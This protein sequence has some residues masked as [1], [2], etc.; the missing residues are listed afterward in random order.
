L[1]RRHINNVGARR[2]AAARSHS[3]VAHARS[4]GGSWS[5]RHRTRSRRAHARSLIDARRRKGYPHRR[6]VL[7]TRAGASCGA[8][9]RRKTRCPGR[10][11]ARTRAV[12]SR[13]WRPRPLTISS[14]AAVPK[15]S[16]RA[17]WRT[18]TVVLVCGGLVLT[19]AMGVRH[20]FG[21]FLQPMSA[22]LHWGRETFAFAMAVQNLMWGF[23]QPVSGM[24]ADRFGTAKIVLA[25]TVLYVLGL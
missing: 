12:A 3:A 14:G 23:M 17:D 10:D 15:L 4:A 13:S 20:G 11:V 24:L 19:L 6:A 22:D 2:V 25:G 9:R 5:G 7:E 16:H 21:L 18:P 1:T 8:C